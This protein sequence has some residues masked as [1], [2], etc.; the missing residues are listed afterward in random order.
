MVVSLILCILILICVLVR[1]IIYQREI[2]HVIRQ[3]DEIERYPETNVRLKANYLDSS[4]EQLMT[5]L[6]EIYATRQQDRI[7][8]ERREHAIRREIENISHDL[9]TPLT[10]VIGYVTL[11]QEGKLSEQE[12][13]EYYNIIYKKSKE[14]Q[15]FIKAFYELSRLEASDEPVIYEEINLNTVLADTLI[16]YYTDFV[17]K[18]IEVNIDLPKEECL[19][20]ADCIQ[21][22][23][24]I[25]NLIQNALKYSQKKFELALKHT[26]DG[27]ELFFK[28]DASGMTKDMIENVFERFYTCDASR[29]SQNTGLGLTIVKVLVE[30]M[31][32]TINAQI[33]DQNFIIQIV[34][35]N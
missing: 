15:S 2:K 11:L 31:N 12:Q 5:R 32:G 1:L 19:Y 26:K 24:I 10:S 28:N 29:N 3:M 14:L 33:I 25:N 9:R 16:S 22:H 34:L 27:Y 21:V 35:K 6:N 17:A 4:L 18:S 23:R 13:K 8:Y 20:L 7:R 30:K